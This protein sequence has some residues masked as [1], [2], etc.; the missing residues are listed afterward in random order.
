MQ[1]VFPNGDDYTGDVRDGKPHGRGKATEPDGRVYEGEWR[2]GVGHGR[3]VLTMPDGE[4]HELT[5]DRGEPVSGAREAAR[6][7]GLVDAGTGAEEER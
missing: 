1:I 5:F 3:A 4:R 6:L 2:A 7:A